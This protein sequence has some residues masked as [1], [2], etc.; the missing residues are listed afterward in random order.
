MGG[1]GSTSLDDL[2][3]AWERVLD[4]DKLNRRFFRELFAWFERAVATCRFPDDDAGPGNVE[5]H[6]IRLITRL[7]FIWFLNEKGLVPGKLFTEQ[8]ARSVLSDHADPTDYYR[9]V[10]QN[11]FF[12]TLNTEIAKREFSGKDRDSHRDFNK[13]RYRDRLA[14]PEGFLRL[15]KKVP[16]VNGGLFDC[17]DDY[18]ARGDGGRRIDA[19][20]DNITTQG[21]DLQ[22][23]TRLFLGQD[24]LFPLLRRYKFTVEE[25]TPLDQDV[26][27][28]PE[29]LGRAFENLLAAYNP[30]T[31]GTARRLTGSY[32]TPRPVVDFM[33][34]EVLSAAL[35]ERATPSDGD[36]EFWRER[37]RYLLDYGNAAADVGE[38]FDPEERRS[39]VQAIGGL[40]VLD[41]AA[42]SGAFPMG[43]LHKLT[44]AL[45][46]LDPRNAIWEEFQKELAKGRASAAF[47]DVADET[48]RSQ[49]LEQISRTFDTYRES[50]FGRKLYLIQ[51]GVF[52]VDIQP[53][54]CQIAKLRFFISLIVEQRTNIDPNKNYGIRPLPNLETHFVAADTL[55]G[56]GTG[57]NLQL[58]SDEVDRI[59]G[60]LRR[61]REGHFNA[62]TRQEKL[63]LRTED[64]K[65]RAALGGELEKLGFPNESATAVARWDPYD[66]NTSAAWFDPE[67][68]FGIGD[69]FDVVIGNPP[70]VRGE[71]IPDKGRL[72]ASYGR[73]FRATADL[74]TYF[75]HKGIELLGPDG[76]LCLITSNK[77]MRTG[78]GKPLRTFLGRE[79]DLRLLLD[80]GRT[81]TF[82]A[83]VRPC[84]VLAGKVVRNRILRVGTVRGD[85]RRL[86]PADFMVRNGFDIPVE[87][88]RDAGW[89]LAP[90]SW[91]RLRAKIEAAG[92]PLGE[93]C[94]LYRGIVTGL[95]RAFVIDADTRTRLIAENPNSAELIRPWLRGR[96]VRRWRADYADLY[97]IFTRHGTP[98]KRYPAIE[99]HLAQFRR[100]LQPKR[101]R[102]LGRGRAPGSYRWFEMQA[103]IAYYRAFD[104]PKI[105]YPDIGQEMRAMLDRR[106]HLMGNTCYIIPGNDACLLAILNSKPLGFYFRL[107]LQC[108]DDPFDGGDLR[109]YTSGM[110]HTPIAKAD[111]KTR[112]T[113][114]ALAGQI[115]NTKENDPAADTA[116]LE[117]RIDDIVCTLYGLTAQDVD[118]LDTAL[119]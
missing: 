49:E 73:F 40:R 37:L 86:D 64:E 55:I 99:A 75:F 74:Y 77:F 87:D 22:V 101:Q 21:R 78:Y 102:G 44:L 96:D 14:D 107:A 43:V 17:L 8:F 113:L 72:H 31:S 45:R 83:T 46:R 47:D 69:G 24:G 1:G 88:L 39:L 95:N 81:G 98:I 114:A 67:W 63:E 10:L 33:V 26:A 61:V 112:Q 97:V 70:Y 2:H 93:L 106:G 94:K 48:L 92:Q 76:L 91:R 57:D 118:V 59:E 52:G 6:V 84:I 71:N 108:L 110:V 100:D 5:R 29:L 13:Y 18:E 12:A 41:P 54:A 105:I 32:Y 23:P 11:L 3:L 90:P 85:S 9:A 62:R 35:A 65:L 16:F 115:S 4:A 36:L 51:N 89:S 117:R 66:Q 56:F 68:M 25:N 27:L 80:L 19:F 109:F 119:A 116:E 58:A 30:E 79:T 82:D 111:S 104:Q 60:C 28:D 15:L 53:V 20:T 38:L 103:T 42:G 7:L 50:D 34:D